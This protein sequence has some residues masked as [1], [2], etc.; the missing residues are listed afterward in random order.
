MK[1]WTHLIVALIIFGALAV[2]AKPGKGKHNGTDS[3]PGQHIGWGDGG[4]GGGGGG[5][6][7]GDGG[8][9]ISV[10]PGESVVITDGEGGGSQGP[11][12]QP[13][14]G[15]LAVL[16]AGGVAGLAVSKLRKKQ[17]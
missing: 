8:A 14:P 13:L 5:S 3:N 16:A 15:A 1:R 4:N 2:E 6:N 7:G 10:I 17:G 9:G 11:S 12:G